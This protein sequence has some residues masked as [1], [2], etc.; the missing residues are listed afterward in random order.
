MGVVVPLDR[1]QPCRGESLAVR[2]AHWVGYVGTIAARAA[3]G[4]T[5][6]GRDC[7][8]SVSRCRP[9]YHA[10]ARTGRKRWCATRP[11]T[12]SSLSI[13]FSLWTAASIRTAKTVR[14]LL[15][16]GAHHRGTAEMVERYGASVW[17]PPRPTSGRSRTRPR[18]TS[19]L[20]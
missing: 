15:T 20:R 7:G 1:D 16:Q 6:A 5:A 18:P 13:R 4:G 19:C 9:H 10:Q 8:L 2:L 12:R 11:M 14:V 17:T 3:V